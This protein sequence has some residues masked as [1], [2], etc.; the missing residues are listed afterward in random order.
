MDYKNYQFESNNNVIK[1]KF[2]N[3]EDYKIKPAAIPPQPQQQ[4]KKGYICI[5]I[6]VVSIIILHN[7]DE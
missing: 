3:N 2:F 6:A 4:L 7:L 1:S 5:G